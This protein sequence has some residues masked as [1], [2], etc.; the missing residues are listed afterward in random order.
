M[1][2]GGTRVSRF[3]LADTVDE[4]WENTPEGAL[5][6]ASRRRKAP[7]EGAGMKCSGVMTDKCDQSDVRTV[8]VGCG[9]RNAKPLCAPCRDAAGRLGM[10]DRREVQR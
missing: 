3:V 7:R 9:P 5:A 4:P 8:A 10:I 1:S 2:A 6:V